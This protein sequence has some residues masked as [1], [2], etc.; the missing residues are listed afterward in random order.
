MGV[1]I[2]MEANLAATVVAGAYF[3][4]RIFPFSGDTNLAVQADL[5][6]HIWHLLYTTLPSLILT[7][8]IMLFYGM[9]SNLVGEDVSE[10]VALITNSLE[11]IYTFNLVLLLPVVIILYG[12]VTKKPTIPM[13]LVSAIIAMLNAFFIRYFSL[14]DIVKSVVD[15]FNIS[16]VQGKDFPAIL[17]NIIKSWRYELYDEY[18]AD[19]F[20]CTFI[21]WNIDIKRCIGSYC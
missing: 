8:F 21:C 15:G 6:K 1:A 19:L 7:A 11:N 16:M 10:K 20:L 2:G 18:I 14:H 4:D 13:M 17:G 12:S 3:G 5:Y 9:N